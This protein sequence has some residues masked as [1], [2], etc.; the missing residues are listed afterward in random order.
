MPS[1]VCQHAHTAPAV[2]ASMTGFAK[3]P[4]YISCVSVL[5]V[6]LNARRS[7]IAQLPKL[8]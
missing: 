8:G 1:M 7:C 6:L 5:G 3:A 4:A 2:V